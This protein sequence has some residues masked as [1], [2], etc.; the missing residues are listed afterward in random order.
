MSRLSNILLDKEILLENGTN[1]LE[2]LVFDV[3]DYTFGINVAKVR[4]VLP[5][6][7]ITSLPQAHPSVRGVVELADE[8]ISTAQRENRATAL[9]EVTQAAKVHRRDCNRPAAGS[10]DKPVKPNGGRTRKPAHSR[11]A[12]LGRKVTG[13]PAPTGTVPGAG[14]RAVGTIQPGRN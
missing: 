13:K 10:R 2:V 14:G 6:T 12:Q 7:E 1:G 4:E 5:A 8:L 9:R 11:V 3:A